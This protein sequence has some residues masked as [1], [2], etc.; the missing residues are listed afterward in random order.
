MSL[1]TFSGLLRVSCGMYRVF[2]N[3]GRVVGYA[4][5]PARGDK[6]ARCS[7]LCITWARVSRWLLEL[8]QALLAAAG[9]LRD[10]VEDLG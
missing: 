9:L 10:Y 7:D 4:A 2:S 8:K 1:S 5:V 6:I 3:W